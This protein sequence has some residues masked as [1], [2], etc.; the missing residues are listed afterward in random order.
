VRTIILM[1]HG[2]TATGGGS[3]NIHCI[4]ERCFNEQMTYLK[5]SGH[6]FLPWREISAVQVKGNKTPVG[7]TFDDANLSDVVSAGILQRLGYSALFFVPTECLDR[8]GHL[9]KSDVAELSGQGMGIGS[10]SH[11]HVQLVRL[12]DSELEEELVRSKAILE[13]VTTRAVEHLSFPGGSYD[14]RVL[15]VARK[16]GYRYFFTSEWGSNGRRQAA[17]QV[18]RRILSLT[19]LAS[20]GSGTSWKCAIMEEHES[21]ST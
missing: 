21:S 17:T 8:S 10:H 18:L 9:A 1:Y 4:S 14:D 15:S 3:A 5:D 12:T 2:V 19:G 6:T 7:L 16:I 20:T 13:D 11:R